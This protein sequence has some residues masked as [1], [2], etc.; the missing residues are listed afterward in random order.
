M[1]K[2]VS[3][4]KVFKNYLKFIEFIIEKKKV[5]DFKKGVTKCFGKNWSSNWYDL[6]YFMKDKML[7]NLIKNEEEY[8]II[9]KNLK[10]FLSKSAFVDEIIIQLNL[11]SI[12]FN[13]NK[14]L[15]NN[16]YY[17]NKMIRERY[18]NFYNKDEMIKLNL[19]S[20]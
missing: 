20:Y 13:K 11:N 4:E 12:F 3:D 15:S 6:L 9:P 19:L 2:V 17:S 10:L 18:K 14:I 1:L 16:K 8:E 5:S 7:I